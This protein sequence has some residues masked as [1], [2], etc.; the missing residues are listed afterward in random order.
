M[1]VD[2]TI[3]D[4]LSFHLTPPLFDEVMYMYIVCDR[5]RSN[6]NY[7]SQD[8]LKGFSNHWPF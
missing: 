7:T 8:F 3:I 6:L 2:N 1:H 4:G 5:M